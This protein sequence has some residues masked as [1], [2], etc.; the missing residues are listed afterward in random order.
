LHIEAFGAAHGLRLDGLCPEL[1][2]FYGENEAGK[3]TLLEFLRTLLYGFSRERQAR[4]LPTVSGELAG[5]S[6]RFETD[7]GAFRVTRRQRLDLPNDSHGLITLEDADGR[8]VDAARLDSLLGGLDESLFCRVFAVGLREMQ[9][10]GT[11]SDSAAA[12][13]LYNLSTGLEGVSLAGV[14]RELDAA[15]SRILGAAGQV[16]VPALAGMTGQTHSLALRA[17]MTGHASV[18]HLRAEHRRLRSEIRRHAGQAAQYVGLVNERE[19]IETDIHKLQEDTCEL[20]RQLHSFDHAVAVRAKWEQRAE[21]NRQLASLGAA[22]PPPPGALE[23]LETLNGRL[24]ARRRMASRL[25]ARRAGR[26]DS[27]GRA[28]AGRRACRT[29]QSPG[30]RRPQARGSRPPPL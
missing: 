23:E 7:D 11:L 22:I 8:Q 1:N 15:R 3:T 10:L 9:E 12:E 20:E 26:S 28:G 13:L 30:A 25:K 24:Q 29:S 4:Y 19:Q 17:Y 6:M 14:R 18:M 27:T 2:V 16:E 21:L 5:G